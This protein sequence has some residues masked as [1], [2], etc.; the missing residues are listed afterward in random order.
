MSHMIPTSLVLSLFLVLAFPDSTSTTDMQHWRPVTRSLAA[1]PLPPWR[2]L[3][4][5]GSPPSIA[6]D[7]ISLDLA[8][9]NEA[10]PVVWA[11][12]SW[13]HP[14]G[15]R[16]RLRPQPEQHPLRSETGD[17]LF[18]RIHRHDEQTLRFAMVGENSGSRFHRADRAV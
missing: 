1:A 13:E 12:P 9:F 4:D 2:R 11:I 18:E 15:R 17:D 6:S 16:P 3:L 5:A 7:G 14:F 10:G 8:G